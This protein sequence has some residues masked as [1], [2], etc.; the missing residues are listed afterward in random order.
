M[1]RTRT[2]R[3]SS[4][5]PPNLSSAGDQSEGNLR[6]MATRD[7]VRQA[8]LQRVSAALMAVAVVGWVAAA[9]LTGIVLFYVAAVLGLAGCSASLAAARRLERGSSTS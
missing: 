7:P 5:L 4:L 9:V 3:R 6:S 8:R 1:R 2:D